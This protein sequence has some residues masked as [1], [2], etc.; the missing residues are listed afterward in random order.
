M[1]IIIIFVLQYIL[2]IVNS[3]S[4]ILTDI[5]RGFKDSLVDSNNISFESSIIESMY[6]LLNR[7]SGMRVALYSIIYWMLLWVELKFLFLYVKRMLRMVFLVIISPIITLT[8]AADKVDDGKAQAFNNWLKEYVSNLLLQPLHCY[9]YLV[10]MFVGNN[11]AIKAPLVGVI[12]LMSLTRGEK[13]VKTILGVTTFANV[14][15]QFSMKGVRG[16]LQNMIPRPG[17]K[18]G[19]PRG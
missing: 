6:S 4:N 14:G 5:A 16:K 9:I 3:F 1:S 15:E 17:P 12:F 2:V 10:F 8:Y 13:I 18:P 19:M 11:I 7:N